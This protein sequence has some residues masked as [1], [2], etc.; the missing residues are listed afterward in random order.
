MPMTRREEPEEGL[1][2]DFY[3]FNLL[4]TGSGLDDLHTLLKFGDFGFALAL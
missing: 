1:F 2:S 4:R 3:P